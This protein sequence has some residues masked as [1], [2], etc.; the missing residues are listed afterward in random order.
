MKI[1]KFLAL[2]MY[3]NQ[4]NLNGIPMSHGTA[5]LFSVFC[6]WSIPSQSSKSVLIPHPQFLSPLG[7][8]QK[9]CKFPQNDKNAYFV[10]CTWFSGT[11]LIDI[12]LATHWIILSPPLFG[13]LGT[14]INTS[15]FET[16][17]FSGPPPM[18]V[19]GFDFKYWAYLACSSKSLEIG[20]TTES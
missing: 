8:P 17:K 5:M 11:Y 15:A 14:L 19:V 7:P 4:T 1:Y 13:P 12:P 2:W 9:A 6:V 16:T 3:V 10:H 20:E 18:G